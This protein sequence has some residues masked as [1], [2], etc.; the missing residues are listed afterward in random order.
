MLL[1][2][3]IYSQS[4]P[5]Y[6]PTNGLVGWWGF[7]GNAQ[8]GSGNGNHG[9]V[10]GATLT[11]DRF[12]NQNSAYDYDGIS[13]SINVNV[14]NIPIGSSPRT[15]ASWFLTTTSYI[16]TSQYTDVQTI[17]GYGSGR[18]GYVIFP[19]N[20]RAPSGRFWFETG[21]QTNNLYSN[22]PVNDGFWHHVVTTYGGPNTSVKVYVDGIF[23]DSSINLSINTDYS[24][25]GI[26]QAPWAN[27]PFRGKIDDI[28][29]WNRA[30]TQQE[31]TNL[32]Q[33]CQVSVTT[34][35][36]NQTININ[37]NAQFI[38]GSSDT[39]ATY[40][41]QTDLG[42]GFQ[43]LNSVAQYSGTTNDTLT[44]SNVTMSNNNQPFRCIVS[45]GSCSDTSNVAVLTVN[46][47][48]GINETS[49]DKLFSVFPN[50]T[51]SLINVKVDTKLIGN[52]YSIY[53][54]TGKV[55]LSGKLKS[56]NTTIEL[57]NLSGGIYFFSVEDILKQNFKIIKSE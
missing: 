45:F 29:I 28:G 34:Q 25:F 14:P 37:N 18:S 48:V 19:Q 40:Q 42:V 4:V 32:Y 55:V 50:P 31:I 12:G 39:N 54:N 1:S 20:V 57:G 5:S 26:G 36:A 9:T 33:P 7:N 47:N 21:S 23:Q 16:P 53:D 56:E 8:D 11:T 27:I 10:N 38:V 22:S 51:Q 6:V 35:P 46:N 30:L 3:I 24:I 43:N 13:N 44:V 49:Q 17:N 52:N 2:N 41:W 15:V